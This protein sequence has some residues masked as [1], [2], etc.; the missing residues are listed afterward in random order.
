[1]LNKLPTGA[2]KDVDEKKIRRQFDEVTQRL[3]ELQQILYAQAK[4]SL[5]VVLQGMDASGKDG[6]V[7]DV[8]GRIGPTGC[9][10]QAF[11][12][13]TDEELAHDFLWRVHP[14]APPRGIIQIFNRSHYEDVLIQRVHHWIDE[15]TVQ[16]R[17]EQINHFESLLHSN[18][19][20]IVKFY[21]H[22][23]PEEQ[24]RRLQERMGD[25]TKR[26]KHNPNDFE[27]RKFWDQYMAAYE[28]VFKH[29]GPDFPWTI[30]PADN[31]W[32]K[33]HLIATKLIEVLEGLDLKYPE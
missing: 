14:H 21:L 15:D 8:F 23:D 29:C 28:D 9:R 6:A 12:R 31:N 25:P 30:V 33:E 18:G 16:R 3:A 17:F 13:P 24:L 1:M 22:V 20:Q 2:T 26:W 19:T 7:R 27:E 32:Y 5:L 10:L 11:K 4:H